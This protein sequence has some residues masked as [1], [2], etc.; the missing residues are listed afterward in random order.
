LQN[1]LNNDVAANACAVPG[2]LSGSAA[3]CKISHIEY[4]I[5]DGTQNIR[6]RV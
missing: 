3:I 5:H 1:Q 2:I 6:R 4:P